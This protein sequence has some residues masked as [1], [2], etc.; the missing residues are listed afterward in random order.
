[1][2]VR[3]IFFDLGEVLIGHDPGH[4]LREIAKRSPLAPERLAAP[5]LG[6]RPCF[7]DFELGHV[8]TREFFAELKVLTQFEGTA[9]ELLEIFTQSFAPLDDNVAVLR[10]LA[11]RHRLAVL[12]NTSPAQIDSLRERYDFLDLFEAEIYS[13]AVSARKP[14]HAI[15][16]HAVQAMQVAP[17]EAL[18][19]DDRRENIDAAAELGWRVIHL[20]RGDDLR[21]ELDHLG[22][23]G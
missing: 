16:R 8:T 10:E 18:L 23:G 19:I 21:E 3:A 7:L 11:G 17:G 12:S 2:P 9:T 14:D 4:T 20:G 1:M 6:P 22:I 15:Y 13:Y 5:F